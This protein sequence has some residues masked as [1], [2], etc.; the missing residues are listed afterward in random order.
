MVLLARTYWLVQGIDV[1]TAKLKEAEFGRQIR[2][3]PLTLNH[4]TA[5]HGKYSGFAG[6]IGK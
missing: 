3:N 4:F 2:S 1:E 6:I 5:I